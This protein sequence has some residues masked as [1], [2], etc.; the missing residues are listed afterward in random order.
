MRLK[1]WI[2]SL[3]VVAL[4]FALSGMA[5][6]ADLQK[7]RTAWLDGQETFPI[8]YA[9]EKGWDKEV[10]LDLEMLYF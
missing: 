1:K 9:K 7:I 4:C 10:G 6:A 8:W 3:A 5:F 2:R